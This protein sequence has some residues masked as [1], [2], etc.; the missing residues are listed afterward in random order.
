[1]SIL[2]TLCI[3]RSAPDCINHT[4][5]DTTR[6]LKYYSKIMN[7]LVNEAHILPR[8]NIEDNLSHEKWDPCQ[9]ACQ[10]ELKGRMWERHSYVTNMW[11][12]K[13]YS[14]LFPV[15]GTTTLT[16]MTLQYFTCRD[17]VTNI[18]NQSRDLLTNSDSKTDSWTLIN[19]LLDC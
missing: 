7:I 2:S 3:L 1:M 13:T 16:F 6:M 9:C 19:F 5:I 12:R 11:K 10:L 14:T 8:P 4:T 15:I 17:R 18:G